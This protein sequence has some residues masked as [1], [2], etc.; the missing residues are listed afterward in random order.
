MV[1]AA[2]KV[3]RET[4]EG[5]AV[6]YIENPPLATLSSDVRTALLDAVQE[7]LN[8]DAV[9]GIVIAGTG[10]VFAAGASASEATDT[11]APSLATLC[12]VIEA[13]EKPVVAAIE[14]ACLG[15]GLELALAAHLRVAHPASRL[16][17][18]EITVGLVPRAGGTQRLPKVVGG[19]AALK[20]LL[21][22]RAVTGESALK[23]GLA[24]VLSRG[25]VVDDAV[26]AAARLAASGGEVRRS[27]ERRD[28]LGEGTAFLEAV[29]AHRQAAAQSALEAPGRLIECVEAA[30][31]LPFEIG[32]GLEEAAYEDLVNSEH[33]KSLRHI[34]A[35]ERQLQAASRWEGRV[36]SRPLK[37][38]GVAGARSEAAELAVLCLDAGFQ[39]TIAEASDEALEGGVSR[40]IEHYDARVSS[41]K[42]TEEAVE[43]VLDRM[44][45]VSGYATLTDS[46]I[47]VAPSSR[48]GRE[49]VSELD[50][51]M[52]AG[53]VLALGTEGADP[54][55]LARDSGRPSDVVSMR[56]PFGMR[57]NRLVEFSSLDPTSP[58]AA[59][60]ARAFLRKL[61]RLMVDVA[62]SSMGIGTRLAEALHAAADLCLEDGARISQIDAALR[63]WGI[64]YGSFQAR[65]LAGLRRVAGP[66]GCEGQRG[67]GLDEA[68]LA[69]G[70]S[71]IAVGRGYYVYRQRGKPGSEDP[72]VQ[73]MVEAD[74][75]A[76][77]VR[78]RSLSD[79]EVRKRCV[80]AM[81]G[82]GAQV[83]GEELVRRPADIDMIAVHGMG[84]ARRTG[85]VMFAADLM[86]LQ[87]VQ[88]V[89]SDMAQVSSRIVA[90]PAVLNDLVR[91]EK[92]FGDL[93]E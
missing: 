4:R 89:L 9:T 83:L 5:I 8:D 67:G 39:V 15:G 90:P 66:V 14:G 46:D 50:G 76:K 1:V 23:L 30:L 19:V 13:S 40:I 17:S 84:F 32:R 24:D 56:F 37:S 60:T 70:R 78:P 31:L 68:L 38:V 91:S 79:G 51:V 80:A 53:A 41:G 16:G 21:S 71:G 55:E 88:K 36:D 45:A 29:A 64:P 35:A 2:N 43:Q 54:N 33:S 69:A 65:D 49:R 44:N 3:R 58:K 81:A 6:L 73:E 20:L 87:E 63:D 25:G 47:V 18:P 62:P 42:M 34:F 48:T 85:G 28:R 77:G 52:R 57:R 27:S 26:T 22:G 75:L 61:D 92:R 74:R 7:C 93:N 10:D 86:G 11:D 82:V 59:A 72:E 12:D